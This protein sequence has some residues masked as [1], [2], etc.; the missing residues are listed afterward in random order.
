MI[1]LLRSARLGGLRLFYGEPDSWL[2]A[3]EEPYGESPPGSSRLPHQQTFRR[4]VQVL[5]LDTTG[6]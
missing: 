3:A 4:Y 5:R 1:H 6:S 2:P